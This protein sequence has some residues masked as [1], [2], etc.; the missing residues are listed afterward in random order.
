VRRIDVAPNRDVV[1]TASDDKTARVWSL[2]SRELQHVLRPATGQNAVGR[3]YG[4][5]IHPKQD[6][7][8]LGGSI[9]A[10]A[11][12]HRILLFKLSSGE[13][14]NSFDARAGDI[15]KLAWTPDGE[16]LIA[17]YAGQNGLR[18][19][20]VDGQQVF[21]QSFDALS[22]G[23]DV[24]RNGMIA[25]TTMDGYVHLLRYQ[26]GQISNVS[27][28]KLTGS[29]PVGVAFSPDSSKLAIGFFGRRPK[30]DGPQI[31]D[32]T[33]GSVLHRLAIPAQTAGNLMTVAWSAD[34]RNVISSGS[35]YNGRTQFLAYIFDAQSGSIIGNHVLGTNTI[36]DM[37]P[38]SNGQMVY[39][40]FSGSWG[41]F[42]PA[43]GKSFTTGAQLARFQYPDA[44]RISA[45]GRRVGNNFEGKNNPGWFDLDKRLV[46]MGALPSD[47]IGPKVP[48][49]DYINTD[50]PSING[51]R[52]KLNRD[53]ISRTAAMLRLSDDFVIGTSTSLRRHSDNG[54]LRWRIRIA[55][56]IRAVNVSADDKYI[57]SANADG[58]ISWYRSEDGV[59]LMSVLPRTDGTWVIWT[60]TGQFDASAG[61]DRQVGW[62]VNRAPGGAADF[63]SLNR[64]R[65]QFS[66]PSYIDNALDG[67]PKDSIQAPKPEPT[68]SAPAPPKAQAIDAI[69]FPPV[70]SAVDLSAFRPGDK[71]V[72]IPFSIRAEGNAQ[73][74]VRINGRPAPDA[75]ITLPDQFD[76]KSR[77]VATVLT[78]SPGSII[79]LIAKDQN[80]V[81]EP[82]GF[83]LNAKQ[84]P[85]QVV[86]LVPPTPTVYTI[87]P[88]LLAAAETVRK[89]ALEQA[90]AELPTAPPAPQGPKL[91]VLSIGVS[92]YQDPKYQL[93]LAAKDSRDFLNTVQGQKGK[94]YSD[95]V[96]RS[97]VDSQATRQSILDGLEWLSVSVGP[98]DVGMLFVAGHGVNAPDGQYYFMPHEGN[99]TALPQTSVPERAIRETLGRMR[100][101][102]LFFVDTCF[103]GNALGNLQSVSRELARMA[104]NLAS[105]ENGVVVFASS[106]GRQL[107]EEN[108]AWGNG[109]FT[110][111]VI[112]GLSG[113]ADLTQSGRVTFK[114]LDFF[115]S[116]EVSKLTEGR[117]TPVTISPIG[118]P[119]FAIAR[120][121][122][123]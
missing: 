91:F 58:T 26:S 70:I 84:T 45:D 73:V 47:L 16:L 37:R 54:A 61:A 115:I 120:L 41:T 113:Q 23:L 76:G 85:K 92:N 101:K 12:S 21:E 71:Q 42:D 123:I 69:R 88:S 50:V 89:I 98:K 86:K 114:G 2:S 117:Q 57:V 56:E 48:R 40:S 72:S 106:S 118:V 19:F 105:A 112:A 52:I 6:L 74:E 29:K 20:R 107:S 14:V 79:Q 64:F 3:L 38:S 17:T 90:L 13:L 77:A 99:H 66:R 9:K 36:Q 96:T 75:Q 80:G 62:S 111:A 43:S 35:N 49:G 32:A 78:P 122:A 67:A 68:S 25:A 27:R 82:L 63:Y 97:L 104:N 65:E 94:L 100:G 59:L 39:A 110:K 83:S 8:A 55:T 10:G 15:K 95:V 4:V 34:G 93:G 119:D 33:S 108:E 46:T 31:L 18:A 60:P 5:A 30:R 53:E 28:Y 116:E 22:Y 87:D 51:N 44:L 1:V 81:S 103:A 109:A 102:A 7:V 11:N 24:A 121:A